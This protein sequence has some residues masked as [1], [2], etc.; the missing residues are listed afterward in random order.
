[1]VHH[2]PHAHV[3]P[4]DTH[5]SL[6]VALALNAGFLGV[7]VVA[8]WLTGS[9]ALLSDAAHMLSDVAA[10][11]LAWGAAMLAR[12]PPTATM[13]FGLARAEVL[14]AFVNALVLLGISAGVTWEAVARL[15]SGSP[16]VPE[17]PVLG[18]GVV[19]LAVNLGSAAV[20]ARTDGANL[21]VRGAMAHMLAD[22]LGSVGVIVAALLMMGGVGE[23]DAVASM[24]V[25]AMVAVSGLGLLRDAGRVLLQLPPADV[26]VV[27]LREG[28]AAVSGV[29][30]VRQLHVWSLDGREPIVSAHL[31]V[32][33]EA[34]AD[35]VRCAAEEAL[36]RQGVV[37][38]T[39]QT[40]RC[41]ERISAPPRARPSPCRRAGAAGSAASPSSRAGLPSASA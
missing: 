29:Q 37:C 25:A 1:M 33:G 2:P 27:G 4:L 11:A 13:T 9:L 39:L 10:L 40:E 22:A 32:S 17:L 34:D 26:D 21:N 12:R 14:G 24:C 5:R 8:W 30:R 35:E 7:E 18:V 23:A 16:P 28:L 3:E 6:L 15:A 38:V 31:V 20:L 19:G 41:A 36:L